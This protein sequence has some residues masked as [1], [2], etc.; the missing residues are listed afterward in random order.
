MITETKNKNN[1]GIKQN[2]KIKNIDN[3]IF[4]DEKNINDNKTENPIEELPTYDININT[5]NENNNIKNKLI[6][7]YKNNKKI[8]I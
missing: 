2:T 6:L 4:H 1:I 8:K 5:T 3:N 7:T